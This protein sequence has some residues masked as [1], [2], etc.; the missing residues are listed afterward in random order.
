M[1]WTAMWVNIWFIDGYKL[2]YLVTSSVVIVVII[3]N[4]YRLSPALYM[5]RTKLTYLHLLPLDV[6][7]HLNIF[8]LESQPHRCPNYCLRWRPLSKYDWQCQYHDIT[9]TWT[10]SLEQLVKTNK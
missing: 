2:H 5:K 10:D 8:R 6:V 1:I 3:L 4:I 7:R 9:W